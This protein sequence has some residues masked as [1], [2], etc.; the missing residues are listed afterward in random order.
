[1]IQQNAQLFAF[2]WWRILRHAQVWHI[3]QYV[4]I[5]ATQSINQSIN[6]SMV[7]QPRAILIVHLI[8]SLE[9]KHVGVQKYSLAALFWSD[10]KRL[11]TLEVA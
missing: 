6:Q 4:R 10:F 2:T 5:P 7:M 9:H 1:V 8:R 11:K 3:E